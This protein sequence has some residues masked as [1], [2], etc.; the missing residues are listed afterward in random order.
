MLWL[1]TWRISG[2]SLAAEMMAEMP[3]AENHVVAE[4]ASDRRTEFDRHVW[5]HTAD[6]FQ[7]AFDL[8]RP[9]ES[10]ELD[11]LVEVVDR[12]CAGDDDERIS[13]TIKSRLDATPELMHSYMQTAGLTRNKILTDLKA[14][15]ASLGLK[16]PGTALNLRR[17]T[18]V[19][20]VAGAYL[21]TRL[22]AVL[23]PL[24]EA[25]D[26]RAA[27]E[28]VNQA[29][30]P[31]W[32]RQERAK[33]QGHQAEYQL[34][35]ML[36]SLGIP[37]E[38]EEKAENPLTRDATVGSVSFDIVVPT[39]M[40]PRMCVK[41]TVQTSNIGQFG[42][43]KGGLEVIEAAA[44]LKKFEVNPVLLAMVDGIGFH[45][46]TAGLTAI[47]TN[48][49]EF[50]QFATIWKA[51]AIAATVSGRDIAVALEP[52]HASEHGSFLSRWSDIPIWELSPEIRSKYAA[53]AVEAGEALA[54]PL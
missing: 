13:R 25:G 21:V 33:R 4:T 41:S 38:P 44:A 22:R 3:L 15:N 27:L 45:S 26:P 10:D 54:I 1:S 18:A 39:P 53:D 31:H 5:D 28:A 29:T 9:L 23:Q 12:I 35:V 8:R 20:A 30:W 50:C 19:W 48:A 40:V 16:I 37:F 14:H 49:D 47:L 51:A 11:A 42:E 34:A 7:V 52:G 36:A 17:S 6:P 43:S 24:C 46:N 2:L 32:I